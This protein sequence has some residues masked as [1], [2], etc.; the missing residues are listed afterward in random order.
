M[1]I[2]GQAHLRG[3]LTENQVHYNTARLHQG[4]AQRVPDDNSTLPG[5]S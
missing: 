3:V 1:L 4:I 5:P 2:L